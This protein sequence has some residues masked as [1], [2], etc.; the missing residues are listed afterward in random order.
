MPVDVEWAYTDNNY[1]PVL[2]QSQPIT[3]LFSINSNMMTEPGEK[4]VLYY[5]FNI[6]S[7]ATTMSPFRHMDLFVSSILLMYCI[8]FRVK[9]L[10]QSSQLSIHPFCSKNSH[11]SFT[12][13]CPISLG[14]CQR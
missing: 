13:K 9:S 5:D 8:Y 1:H 6:A 4:R 12:A 14:V 2:L 7:E 3:T 10:P 11:E